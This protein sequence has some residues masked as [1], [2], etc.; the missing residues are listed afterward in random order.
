MKTENYNVR[1]EMFRDFLVRII[2]EGK[3]SKGN[4]KKIYNE[5]YSE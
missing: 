4:I 1:H 3:L 2:S 5:F